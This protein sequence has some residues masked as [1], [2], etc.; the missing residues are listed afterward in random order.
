[1]RLSGAA[2]HGAIGALFTAF[3]IGLQA[4]AAHRGLSDIRLQT[5]ALFFFVQ[6]PAIIAATALRHSGIGHRV[7]GR[8]ALT[9][10]ILGVTLFAGDLA[11]KS[12]DYGKL[13][14]MA[15]PIGGMLMIVGWVGFAISA[16]T[17]RGPA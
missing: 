3:G 7:F 2:L 15:A 8:I 6:G 5:A 11:L 13:F 1:M 12:M 16:L 10:V 4:L 9:M 17:K 14:A